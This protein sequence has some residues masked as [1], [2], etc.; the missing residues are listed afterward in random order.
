MDDARP[1]LLSV[2]DEPNVLRALKR[3]LRKLDVD[4]ITVDSGTEGLKVLET[5]KV[6]LI[7][8]DMR[9][10]NMTGPEFL[11]KAA[12][13]QPDTRR[14]VL[15]GYADQDATKEAINSGGI[16]HYLDKPWDDDELRRIVGDAIQLVSL[17]KENAQL[18]T[19]TE[20][21]Y[22]EL[23]QLNQDLERRVEE[24]T[25]D[26]QRATETLE[27]TLG[28]LLEAQQQMVDLVANT[29]AMP[30]PESENTHRKSVL[31]LAIAEEMGLDEDAQQ[32]LQFAVRLHRLGWVGLPFKLRDKPYHAMNG[33]EQALFEQHPAYAEGVLLSIPFLKRAAEIIAHQHEQFNGDGFPDRKV[34]DGIPIGARILAIARDYY[35]LLN[36]RLVPDK[37]VPARAVEWI[38]ERSGTY[39]DPELCKRFS[40]V[41]G[42]I[43]ELDPT[44]EEI[45]LSA[46][47][48]QEGMRLTRDLE[49]KEGVLLLPKRSLLTD[50]VVTSLINMEQ[51][52]DQKLDVYVANIK[53]EE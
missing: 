8:S 15:T 1:V 44:I 51:R 35:D 5:Q 42:K 28:N 2:D 39:Y 14:M 31:A 53:D 47:L 48:L 46:R 10:P 11:A 23:E 45:C 36:G 18:T 17:R 29:A 13:L 4:I 37:L 49:T 7:I 3:T 30:N 6:D 32:H 9:M 27:E 33:D 16:T 52:S 24:R 50:Q 19:I 21:Q 40:R 22:A 38:Q 12:E 43:D 34:G 25:L 41:V 26:L 20:R